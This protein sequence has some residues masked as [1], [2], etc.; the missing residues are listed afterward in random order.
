MNARHNNTKKGSKK[1][2]TS[3][4]LNWHWRKLE[5][6]EKIL[7]E[8]GTDCQLTDKICLSGW[9]T[10]S[11]H[12]ATLF[13]RARL[14]NHHCASR[15]P[16]CRPVQPCDTLHNSKK[17]L[18]TVLWNPVLSVL[19]HEFNVMKIPTEIWN[20]CLEAKQHWAYVQVRITWW[21]CPTKNGNK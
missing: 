3:V 15:L 2:K 17:L 16:T 10:N 6:E 4:T 12:N 7:T 21:K 19:Y 1:V 13:S 5:K 20:D 18:K 14:L 11:S 9:K 8:E